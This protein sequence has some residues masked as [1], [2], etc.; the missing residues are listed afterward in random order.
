MVN[1]YRAVEKIGDIHLD[2]Q[3]LEAFINYLNRT[4]LEKTHLA[5]DDDGMETGNADYNKYIIHDEIFIQFFTDAGDYDY[6]IKNCIHTQVLPSRDDPK[7]E[8]ITRQ[9]IGSIHAFFMEHYKKYF[10]IRVSV[11][12]TDEESFMHYHRDLAAEN[13][14]RFL[15]DIT[16]PDNN[17]HGIEVEDRLYSLDRLS[18][19]KLD[20]TR[21]HRS[22]NFS[23]D[24]KKISFIVQ[25]ISELNQFVDYQQKHLDLF[26]ETRDKEMSEEN[27][28]E[29]QYSMDYAAQMLGER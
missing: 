15:I 16:H 6:F 11:S 21:R 2:E 1:E 4:E 5:L 19:Y 3:Q 9:I 25:C 22:S 10:M 23:P 13:A 28:G 12:I 17:M 14:D 29:S 18:V 7:D 8:L 27:G 20:T 26:Y 24:H